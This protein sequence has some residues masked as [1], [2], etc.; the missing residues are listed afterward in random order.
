MNESTTP[1]TPARPRK[2]LVTIGLVA[3]GLSVAGAGAAAAVAPHTPVSQAVRGALSAV[4]VEWTT[5]TD[6]ATA[7]T[8]DSEARLNAFWEAGYTSN[9]AQA[10]VDLWHTDTLDAKAKAGQLVLDGQAVPFAPGTHPDEPVLS[11]DAFWEAGY[12]YADA[13]ALAALWGTDVV[14]TKTAAA[15]KLAAGETLPIAPGTSAPAS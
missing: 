2:R 11:T 8:P 14:E 6:G 9:D 13:E 3:A 7:L 4:G 1:R 5:G 15:Q 10:L 12:T